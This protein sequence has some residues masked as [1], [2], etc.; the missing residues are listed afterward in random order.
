M[1][2]YRLGVRRDFVAQHYLVGGDFGA[3]GKLHS[4]HY[5]IEVRLEGDS[6]DG[7]GFLV[8][9]VPVEGALDALV[10]R[11]RDATLNELDE[12]TGLNPGIEVLAR[13]SAES[14]RKD[15]PLESLSALE[16]TIW[17]SDDAW[18]THR[19]EL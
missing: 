9:I 10:A 19:M 13:V 5:R 15:L 11:Y 3:E 2:A 7:H 6:L 18:A 8:D 17:E 1:A 16:V 14:L 4:H 12:L